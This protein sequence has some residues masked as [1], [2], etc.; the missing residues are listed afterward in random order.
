MVSDSR[1]RGSYGPFTFD[2][3]VSG[4]SATALHKWRL[5]AYTNSQGPEPRGR[6]YY[7][8]YW[9]LTYRS[10]AWDDPFPLPAKRSPKQSS[11]VS[12]WLDDL[13]R[14]RLHYLNAYNRI[15][16]ASDTFNCIRMFSR[17]FDSPNLN[18]N[19]NNDYFALRYVPNSWRR[20]EGLWVR[21][22][23]IKLCYGTATSKP[24]DKDNKLWSYS[25]AYEESITSQD[26]IET[27]Y[28]AFDLLNG[29]NPG[30]WYYLTGDVRGAFQVW[31]G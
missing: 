13:N 16:S 18:S 22:K 9:G 25:S 29:L 5:E 2:V 28:V 14:V 20:G 31:R 1:T 8:V 23:N 6:Q 30:D 4:F 10:T 3:N 17:R 21:G 15:A 7:S 19:Y 24:P 26:K 12:Q 11:T 27:K